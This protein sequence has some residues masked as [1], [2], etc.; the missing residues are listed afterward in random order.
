MQN[1]ASHNF[2]HDVCSCFLQLLEVGLDRRRRG[3][4]VGGGKI[5]GNH[6]V[7]RFWGKPSEADENDGGVSDCARRKRAHGRNSGL[8]PKLLVTVFRRHASRK[9]TPT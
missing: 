8:P 3:M 7:N 2:W 6:L 4:L 1:A 5:S 9:H